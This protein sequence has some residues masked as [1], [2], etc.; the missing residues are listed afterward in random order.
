MKSKVYLGFYAYQTDIGKWHFTSYL[1]NT[2]VL[3]YIPSLSD[4]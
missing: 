1:Q 2:D 4:Y 3:K